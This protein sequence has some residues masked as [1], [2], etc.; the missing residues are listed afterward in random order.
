MGPVSAEAC[1]FLSSLVL[2][3]GRKKDNPSMLDYPVKLT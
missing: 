2:S 1:N 3:I